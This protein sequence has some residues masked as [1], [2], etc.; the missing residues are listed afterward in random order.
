MVERRWRGQGTVIQ[1]QDV[2]LIY[3]GEE[4]CALQGV[5]LEV[6]RGEFVVLH[7]GCGSGKS[8][9][10]RLLHRRM[11]PTRGEVTIDGRDL[12]ILERG[13]LPGLRR[14]L[15]WL[16]APARL[17]IGRTLE[18]NVALPLRLLGEPTAV[19]RRKVR[20]ALQ[21]VGLVHKARRRA[22]TVDPGDRQLTALARALVMAPSAL[23]ADEL[24]AD[25]DPART[26][27]VLEVLHRAHLRGTTILMAT[28][29]PDLA[30]GPHRRVVHLSA[31]QVVSD[32]PPARPAQV[33]LPDHPPTMTPGGAPCAI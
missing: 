30:R 14:R 1:F 27:E 16:E 8:S 31:G 3:P 32:D 6:H 20:S 25:L 2:D 26:A 18:E 19:L 13:E 28:H 23:L 4:V 10:L 29:A 7:G 9:L 21:E 11:R 22:E 12:G 33:W 17:L 5:T 15:A 24:T